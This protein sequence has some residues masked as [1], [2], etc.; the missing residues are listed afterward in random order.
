MNHV[1]PSISSGSSPGE[2]LALASNL[3]LS[4]SAD[5]RPPFSAPHWTGEA[6]PHGAR[7]V[8]LPTR[9]PSVPYLTYL[10]RDLG[11]DGHA[12]FAAMVKA[13]Q[14]WLRSVDRRRAN[15]VDADAQTKT[16]PRECSPIVSV[17]HPYVPA[18][19]SQRTKTGGGLTKKQVET[20]LARKRWDSGTKKGVFEIVYRRRSSLQV[21]NESGIPVETLYVYAS[22]LR[23]DIQN[24]DLR[25]QRKAA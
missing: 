25:P 3:H 2:T 22:R 4:P 6:R 17:V 19:P 10:V 8:R 24:A 14:P 1:D 21:S 11:Y 9:F 5:H 20:A 15:P 16:V 18:A 23:Q 7:R 12:A 13:H